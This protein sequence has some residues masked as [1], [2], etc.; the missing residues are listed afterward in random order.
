MNVFFTKTTHQDY[1]VR[2][3][4]SIRTA[5]DVVYDIGIGDV[6][7]K[8]ED[9]VV[10]WGVANAKRW[11]DL[12]CD[13]VLIFE[14]GYLGDRQHW[15]SLGWDDLNGQANFYNQ[16]VAED[17]WDKYWKSQLSPWKNNGDVVLIAGQV[18][19]DRSLDDCANYNE[20]LN[21]TISTLKSKGHDVV[22][23]PHPLEKDGYDVRNVTISTHKDFDEDLL[24]AKC[25]VTW[26]STTSVTAAYIGVPSVTF[27]DYA[28]TKEVSS[29][30]LDVL[31][32][33]PD[34]TNWGRKLAYCQWNL[35]ELSNGEAWYHVKSRFYY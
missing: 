13:N 11:Q 20:W 2:F 3:K 15:L 22:F 9:I 23:R 14:R 21:D 17:R 29:H 24:R 32:F 6:I 28:M 25:L 12:G 16:Y 26:S 10:V 35:D 18:T 7:P 19:R 31:D 8:E 1:V 27:S 5:G 33:K 34:R 30:S 4:Q